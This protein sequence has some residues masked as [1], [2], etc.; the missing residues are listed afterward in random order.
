M[1]PTL[2]TSSALEAPT[3]TTRAEYLRLSNDL[4]SLCDAF[5]LHLP[6][7]SHRDAAT[8]VLAIECVDRILDDLP[9]PARREQF[10]Q[11]IIAFLR[12][13]QNI[14]SDDTTTELVHRLSR[15]KLAV[16]RRKVS[17]QFNLVVER[18]FANAEQMRTAT[19]ASHFTACART[20]GELMVELLL[21]ILQP[22]ATGALA[23]FLRKV[24][25]PANLVDKWRDAARDYR[26]GELSIRPGIEFRLYLAATFV[27][28][29]IPLIR[30]S[31][32]NRKILRW[33]W[34]SLRNEM[35]P[36]AVIT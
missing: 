27:V 13:D 1:R 7:Q 34:Q 26:V 3:G 11:A 21:L 19:K 35:N 30:M 16:A 17:P 6:A 22:Q 15:L 5:D 33:S 24:A 14:Q 28:A 23:Y 4:H 18:I 20:E 36:H 9:A 25:E 2:A 12:D 8:L 10:A 32:T 31:L 29:L